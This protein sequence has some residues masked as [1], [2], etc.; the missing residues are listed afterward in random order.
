[1]AILK[2]I[3]IKRSKLGPMDPTQSAELIE[4][5]GIKNNADQ[6][7]K[8][9]VTIIEKQ[10]WETMLKE[11]GATVDP[12][13][14]RANLLLEGISLKNSDGKILNIGS[15]KIKVFGETRPCE[16]MDQAYPG[17]RNAMQANWNGGVYG[18]ILQGGHIK[19]NDEVYFE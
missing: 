19:I 18:V 3:W 16:R 5:K 8:R 2:K 1:M 4:N 6:N 17:L 11:L 12:I 13:A 15:C 10:S 7:G 14:R 9:Q